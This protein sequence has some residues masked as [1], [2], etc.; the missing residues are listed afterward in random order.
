MK[1]LVVIAVLLV[2]ALA[3][4]AGGM[5]LAQNASDTPASTAPGS[6]SVN[7][8]NQQTGIWV[9]GQGKATVTPDVATI[10]LGVEAQASTVSEAQ[11]QASDAMNK[12]IAALKAKGVAGKDIQTRY[13]N[14]SQVTR[15]DDKSQTQVVTGYR[16]SNSVT[17]KIRDISA[18]GAIIDDVADSGR[19][20][21]QNQRH[22]LLARESRGRVESGPR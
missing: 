14:I 17:A 10:Q 6:V 9:N 12:V 18:A 5:A 1:R 3:L 21:D 20:S 11:G 19:R 13:F 4:G 8:G 15:W 2:I 7:V 16:V 22:Q